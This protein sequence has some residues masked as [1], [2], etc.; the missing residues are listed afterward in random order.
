MTQVSEQTPLLSIFPDVPKPPAEDILPVVLSPGPQPEVL[1]IPTSTIPRHVKRK[2]ITIAWFLGVA[3]I[4]MGTMYV[5]LAFPRW[6]LLFLGFLIGSVMLIFNYLFAVHMPEIE[7]WL[8]DDFPRYTARMIHAVVAIMLAATVVLLLANVYSSGTLMQWHVVFS[9][10]YLMLGLL[11][12]IAPCFTLARY[13]VF[14]LGHDWTVWSF[15]LS[16]TRC[17]YFM[18]AG[19]CTTVFLVMF[20]YYL[21]SN[22][23]SLLQC[24]IPLYVFEFTSLCMHL[25]YQ[26]AEIAC[27]SRH[28]EDLMMVAVLMIIPSFIIMQSL[29]LLVDW[30]GVL[31]FLSAILP[32]TSICV[33]AWA[34]MD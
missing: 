9:P 33:Y 8:G 6:S 11:L 20:S 34:I 29:I 18:F 24:F 26:A 23:F 4:I 17:L 21:K 5:Y 19:A 28:K 30:F 3:A 10:L 27:Q 1:V 2:S 32:W 31:M 14:H 7:K 13:L 16:C 22:V 25:G 12:I 15:V